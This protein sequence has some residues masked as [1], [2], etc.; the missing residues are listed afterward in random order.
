M[1]CPN[2]RSTFLHTTSYFHI[3]TLYSTF[4]PIFNL[5]DYQYRRFDTV[6]LVSKTLTPR[7]ESRGDKIGVISY[8]NNVE[9]S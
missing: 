3:I 5:L 7:A 6:F 1:T 4:V 9:M 2:F 8:T